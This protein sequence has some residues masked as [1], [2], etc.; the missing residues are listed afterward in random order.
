M[1]REAEALWWH[2]TR[3]KICSHS[4]RLAAKGG[5]EGP[6]VEVEGDRKIRDRGRGRDRDQDRD[7]DRDKGKDKGILKR[8]A[9]RRVLEA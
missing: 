3:S 5:M 2:A 6:E 4:P 9:G 8:G 7:Q 1:A